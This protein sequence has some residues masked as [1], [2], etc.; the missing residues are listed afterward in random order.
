M[1]HIDGFIPMSTLIKLRT[2][3][4]PQC[5]IGGRAAVTAKDWLEEHYGATNYGAMIEQLRQDDVGSERLALQA[6]GENPGFEIMRARVFEDGSI[7][8][9]GSA[10]MEM[11]A[12]IGEDELPHHHFTAAQIYGWHGEA[13]PFGE[14]TFAEGR[15]GCQINMRITDHEEFRACFELSEEPDDI[16]AAIQIAKVVLQPFSAEPFGATLRATTV[17]LD[18]DDLKVFLSAEIED[19]ALFSQKVA[20]VARHSGF[21]DDYVPE[22]AADA[23]FEAWCGCNDSASPADLGFEIIDWVDHDVT[24]SLI[25]GF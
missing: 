6:R 1:Q 7:A 18:G 4:G 24:E 16:T 14:P 23:I 5:L 17:E 21:D 13:A 2:F 8:T 20:V 15:H 22:S 19:P 10:T 9:F 3:W 25:P 11:P 12:E